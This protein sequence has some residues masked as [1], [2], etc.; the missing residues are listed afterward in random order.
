M[1]I[2]TYKCLNCGVVPAVFLS[3][4]FKALYVRG[5]K[6]EKI[7]INVD[8]SFPVGFFLTSIFTKIPLK[9]V[10]KRSDLT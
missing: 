2:Y 8:K 7:K 4:V 5:V 1:P 6:T 3:Y 10:S 9:F